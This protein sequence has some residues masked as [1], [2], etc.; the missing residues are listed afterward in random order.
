[1]TGFRLPGGGGASVTGEYPVLRP[2]E[3]ATA[4]GAER[5]GA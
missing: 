4:E 1:V 5:R 2:E 3:V